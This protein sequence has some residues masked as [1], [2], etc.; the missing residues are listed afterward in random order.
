MIAFGLNVA[1]VLLISNTSAVV[2][3]LTGVVKDILLVVLS[4]FIFGS[5]VSTIQVIGYTIAL[6]G[7]NTHKEYK[8][9]SELISKKIGSLGLYHA[10]NSDPVKSL[11]CDEQDDNNDDSEIAMALLD[12]FHND[13]DR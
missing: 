13:G 8:K 7:I 6:L 4:V 11:S 9:D 2:V 3:T 10:K 1:M 12:D 5:P